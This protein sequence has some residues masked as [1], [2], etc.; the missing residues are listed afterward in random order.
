M[1]GTP[2]V[3][4][5]FLRWELNRDL[6]ELH[7]LYTPQIDTAFKAKKK[8]E[9]EE[10]D[11]HYY[12]E[13]RLVTDPYDVWQSDQLVRKA[14][15]HDIQVPSIPFGKKPE[16]EDDDE[17]WQRTSTT[18][19][20][21][22]KDAIAQRIRREIRAEKRAANDEWR[23]TGTFFLALAGFILGLASLLVKTKQPDPCQRNYYRNDE[24]ACVFAIP[25]P[26]VKISPAPSSQS[27]VKSPPSS[28]SHP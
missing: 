8:D 23:K 18:Y 27:S 12:N 13:R 14:R 6:K 7:D 20:W 10:L 4:G 19:E 25:S 3:N 28:K 17:N 21:V 15:K 24:G 2:I 26:S 1:I 16:E 22:L 11:Y 5:W 9:G